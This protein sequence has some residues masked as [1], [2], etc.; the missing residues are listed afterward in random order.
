[1]NDL[2]VINS[3]LRAAQIL[4]CFSTEKS[5]YTNAELAKR[6]DLNK[7]T[8]T[9][10]LC[11]LEKAGF[12]ERHPKTRE[13]SLT[14]RL[15]QIG[16]VYIS[17]S[18]LHSQA[19]PLLNQLANKCKET[20][21]LGV[22]TDFQVFYLDKVEGQ[23]PISMMSR[24]GKIFPAYCTALGKAMLAHMPAFAVDRYIE[25][26]RFKRYTP[27]TICDANDF[28]KEL[29]RTVE[30][31]YAVD[32]Y[33]HEADVKCIAAPIRDMTGEV[34]AAISISGPSFRMVREKTENEIVP[35]LIQTAKDISVRLG[36]VG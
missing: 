30:K 16:N 1:M 25:Q 21:H 35:I 23:H 33:E 27:N 28:R 13:Y 12:V 15:Y 3:V 11:S 5:S 14:Y 32:E 26:T 8:I 34:V 22:L 17:Q 6:L 4:E 29:K 7:S 36:Y 9:R 19:M 18:T 20:V 24:I 31:G 10:L 2:Y